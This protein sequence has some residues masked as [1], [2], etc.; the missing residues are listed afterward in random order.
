MSAIAE[1][2]DKLHRFV[3]SDW[4]FDYP[5]Q[6]DLPD[7]LREQSRELSITTPFSRDEIERY[8]A[9]LMRRRGVSGPMY[10][11]EQVRGLVECRV[12]FALAFGEH[13]L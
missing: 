13:R 9:T 4:P 6:S 12:Q 5:E 8:Q 7:V 11:V 2:L 1:L 3:F 10:T